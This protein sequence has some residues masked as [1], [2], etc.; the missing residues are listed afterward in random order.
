M[1]LSIDIQREK[2]FCEKRYSKIDHHVYNMLWEQL[3][4]ESV[5]HAGETTLQVL[6]ENGH[7]T[8]SK[9]YMWLY[10]ASGCARQPIVLY[11]YQP[12]GKAEH[13]ENFLK[14]FS[15]RLHADGY[16]GYHKLSE[17]TRVVGCPSE[18]LLLQKKC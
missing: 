6:K 10:R 4:K 1:C 15:G 16:Q 5:L 3:C 14:E 12:A 11:E 17:N 8:A 13:S 18:V 9:R 2:R 7:P